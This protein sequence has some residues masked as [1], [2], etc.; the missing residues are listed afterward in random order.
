MPSKP[1]GSTWDA[2]WLGPRIIMTLLDL[3]EP[4]A[5]PARHVR[6]FV[7]QFHSSQLPLS[8]T[9][10]TRVE[11][12]GDKSTSRTPS[13]RDA[14]PLSSKHTSR[15]GQLNTCSA[16]YVN[17]RARW[18]PEGENA[19][20]LTSPWMEDMRARASPVAGVTVVGPPDGVWISSCWRPP[21][22][23]A[24]TR[25]VSSG[26]TAI[27][28]GQSAPKLY[29]PIWSVNFPSRHLARTTLF[30]IP[31]AELPPPPHT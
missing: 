1:F 18:R 22:A 28:M 8:R 6:D 17:P 9:A 4:F 10:V 12:L 14:S 7:C 13:Q 3:K 29:S 20:H 15:L 24:T 19:M 31:V 25:A 5:K 21:L 23:M 16:P 26:V 30:F 2:V 11:G 27:R